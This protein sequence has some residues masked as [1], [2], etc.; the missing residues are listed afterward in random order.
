MFLRQA[1]TDMMQ[2]FS[3]FAFFAIGFVCL[4]LP[5]TP[6]LRLKLAHLLLED[7][8][9]LI[10]IGLGFFGLAFFL[11]MGFYCLSRGRYLLLRMGDLVT[12]VDMSVLKKTIRPLLSKQFASRV[13]LTDLE[14]F[15]D[16]QLRIGLSILPMEEKEKEKTLLE[17]ERHLQTL[18]S[19]RFGY[20]RPF[21]VQ[22]KE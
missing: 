11:T 22:L 8:R 14:V 21:I 13:H 6:P 20:R 5:F 10:W 19:E 17:A 4:C 7:T 2:I 12:E 16:S 15:K 3:V 1:L 18:L 9:L